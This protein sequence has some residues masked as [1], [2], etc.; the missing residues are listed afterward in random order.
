MLPR[1]TIFAFALALPAASALAQT[2]PGEIKGQD[3]TTDG[4]RSA[5]DGWSQ[6]PVPRE[7]SAGKDTPDPGGGSIKENAE[8]PVPHAPS[9]PGPGE[10]P[11]QPLDHRHPGPS[12]KNPAAPTR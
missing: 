4:G 8:R 10:N 3:A 6:A 7:Q 9:Q 2:P 12:G 11:G 1:L 5:I